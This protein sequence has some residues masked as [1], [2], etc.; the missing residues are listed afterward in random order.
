M[1]LVTLNEG[2]EESCQSSLANMQ[3]DIQ[4][5]ARAGFMGA[6]KLTMPFCAETVLFY[7][8]PKHVG[9]VG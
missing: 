4:Q 9:K 2:S 8:K 3:R 6:Q 1:T 7:W 5:G